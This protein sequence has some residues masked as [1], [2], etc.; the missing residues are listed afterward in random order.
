MQK[1]LIVFPLALAAMSCGGSDCKLHV[2]LHSAEYWA[3]ELGQTEA[4]VLQNHRINMRNGPGRGPKVGDMIPGSRAAVLSE[5][6]D[7][8]LVKS[9]P[10]EESGWIGKLQ[11]ARTLYQNINTREPCEP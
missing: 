11:A 9:P 6:D 10:S 7:H 3:Q 1:W 5:A 2:E 4:W 8:Y